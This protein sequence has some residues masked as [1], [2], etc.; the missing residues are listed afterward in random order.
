[1][2]IST[3]LIRGPFGWVIGLT[4]ALG[5]VYLLLATIGLAPRPYTCLTETHEK[6]SGLLGYDFEISET[7]CSTLGEDASISV[8][9]SKAGQTNKELL[10]KYGPAGVDPLPI[11]TSVDQHTIQISVPRISDVIFRRDNWEGLSVIYSI[12]I[13]DYPTDSLEKGG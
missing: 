7:D 6:I 3:R 5:A 8:F 12:G 1:M 4:V 10:F 11:I 9:A 2:L 13:I